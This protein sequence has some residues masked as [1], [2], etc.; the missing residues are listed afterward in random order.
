MEIA[1]RECLFCWMGN[2]LTEKIWLICQDRFWQAYAVCCDFTG[3]YR[4]TKEEAIEAWN[5]RAGDSK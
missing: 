4:N 5:T 3:P 2:E 1:L